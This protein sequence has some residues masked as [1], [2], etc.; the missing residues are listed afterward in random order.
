MVVERVKLL[1][2]IRYEEVIKMHTNTRN[3]NTNVLSAVMRGAVAGAVATVAMS[4]HMLWTRRTG[5]V[6]ALAPEHVTDATF[7]AVGHQP[8]NA[9]HVVGTAIAHL[10]FGSGTGALLAVATR[11]RRVPVGGGTAYGLAIAALSYQ[12][13]VPALGILPPLRDAPSGRQNEIVVSHVIY[14]SVLAGMLNRW[15]G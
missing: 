1:M 8:S 6:D 15:R 9:E 7:D 2:S 10:A 13:W 4:G 14:G 11:G 12:G 3:R 5:R